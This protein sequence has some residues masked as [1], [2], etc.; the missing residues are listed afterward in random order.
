[1]NGGNG[2][3]VVLPENRPV[4]TR[5]TAIDTPPATA[6]TLTTPRVVRTKALTTVPEPTTTGLT[7]TL[8][9]CGAACIAGWC[10]TGA[11]GGGEAAVNARTTARVRAARGRERPSA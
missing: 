2:G 7:L 5:G 10:G 9:I 3:S 1:M 6:T 8:R 11:R 4:P